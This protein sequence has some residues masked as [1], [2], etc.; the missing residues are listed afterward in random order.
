MQPAIFSNQILEEP[1]PNTWIS[2]QEI[3]LNKLRCRDKMA[4]R[5]LYQLYSPAIYGLILRKLNDK[6][7]CD[8]ALEQ[9]FVQAWSSVENYDDTK[10]SLFT[11]LSR[12]A[13]K[14]CQDIQL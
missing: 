6:G 2:V 11:W 13:N 8:L 7:D 3:C 9:T 4:F 10:C 1:T 14:E 5:M 12:L